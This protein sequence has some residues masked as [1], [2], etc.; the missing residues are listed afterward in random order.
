[1]ADD[2]NKFFKKSDSLKESKG[3]VVEIQVKTHQQIKYVR[4]HH[5]RS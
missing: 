3:V 1:M 2:T 4:T 5:N